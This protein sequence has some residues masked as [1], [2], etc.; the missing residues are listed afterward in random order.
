MGRSDWIRFKRELLFR[1]SKLARKVPAFF[2]TVG[3]VQLSER[4]L[5]H[6]LVLQPRT[7]C[8]SVRCS[9]VIGVKL[10]HHPQWEINPKYGCSQKSEVAV[11]SLRLL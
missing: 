1:T 4:P 2:V 3:L 11:H 8:T 7:L 6:D 10:V 5:D 9:N